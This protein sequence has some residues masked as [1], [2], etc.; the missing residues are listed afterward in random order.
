MS[1]LS[2]SRA[3]VADSKLN[4]SRCRGALNAAATSSNE[5]DEAETVPPEALFNR[6][7]LP[8]LHLYIHYGGV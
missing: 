4:V 2:N 1:K 7:V 3:D 8:I 5:I 6:I